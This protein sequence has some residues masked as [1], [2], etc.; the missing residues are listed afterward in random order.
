M[1]HDC[2]NV[3]IVDD[4]SIAAAEQL[5]RSVGPFV[6]LPAYK[7]LLV[8]MPDAAIAARVALGVIRCAGKLGE[9]RELE[10]A[11][12]YWGTLAGA[13]D[14]LETIAGF[15]KTLVREGRKWPAVK[16]ARAEAERD[17]RARAYYLLA[18]CL[19]IAGD[20]GGALVAFG[21]AATR[22]D[23]E[24][25]AA[26]VAL[27][28]RAKRVERMIGDQTTAKLALA[29]A[30]AADPTGAPPQS[31]LAIGLGRL[32]SPSRF[33]RASGLSLLEEL[34]REPTT[35]L[36]KLAILFA[37][38][39]ADMLGDDLTPIEA[40][41]I[42][43]TIGHVTDEAA[44]EAALAR[45]RAAQK[46]AST[47]GEAQKEAILLAV[48]AAPE[49][50]SLV[51]RARAI[52]QGSA[53]TEQ[54]PPASLSPDK[55]ASD[56]LRACAYAQDA[57]VA[58]TSSRSRDAAVAIH[59]AGDLVERGCTLSPPLWIAARRGLESTD[60][61]ARDAAI[62]LG[63]AL[64]AQAIA[65]PIHGFSPLARAFEHAGRRDLAFEA[66][67]AAIAA[68]EPHALELQG[69]I[70]QNEGWA[71]ALRGE[72]DKA[73]AALRAAKTHLQEAAKAR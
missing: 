7:R 26:D 18:R 21:E 71:L 35:R 58:L 40:D 44:K 22:A 38:E 64:L 42:A 33:V 56:A 1:A 6:A 15:C 8:R 73:I 53:A 9:D 48:Q 50:E 46:I 25:G 60:R 61:N 72:R 36:G 31:K 14:H 30:Q 37:A 39:H 5:E 65:P 57:L 43:A 10:S 63:T 2:P 68:K 23:K 49:I 11:A 4:L 3:R 67:R 24:Q 70:V 32:R 16:L 66:I 51:E 27:A 59:A 47:K 12:D 20:G 41:R 13:G 17:G 62:R 55:L 52:L 29:D 54:K 45:L 69:G 34:A 19:E 28:A